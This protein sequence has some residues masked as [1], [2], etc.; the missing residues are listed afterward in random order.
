MKSRSVVLI[1]AYEPDVSLI[2][3]LREIQS[4]TEYDIVVV[5][6]GSSDNSYQVLSQA[7]SFA[8]V[9]NHPKNMGKGQAIKTGLQYIREHYP[10][11]T[12]IATMDADGQHK[13][14]DVI[15]LINAASDTNNQLII[16][17]RKFSG[18][19]PVRSKV[20][21][22][23]TRLVFMAL[24]RVNVGDTQ[25]GLRAFSARM[26]PFMLG[27]EGQRYEYEMNVL[28]G[29]AHRNIKI[30]EIPIETV[31]INNNQSSH[32]NTF[33]DSYMIYK[34]ILMFSASS[35]I[36]FLVDFCLYSILIWLTRDMNTEIRVPASN[37]AARVVSAS[38][39]FSINK[40]F[41]FKSRGSTFKAAA[42]YFVL[43]SGILCLNTFL[44]TVLVKYILKNK[45]I[46]KLLVEITLFFVNWSVQK[47]LKFKKYIK[48]GV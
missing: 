10:E 4:K 2:N 39:N 24:T 5:N 44:L 30:T 19:I 21:N 12:V 6:D 1:P 34:E 48:V 18:K 16:G 46:S 8:A 37:I 26:I 47:F 17:S 33:K 15:K 23:I 35:L 25:T 42:E 45:L 3:L 22:I 43:A 36:C 28:L 40:R 13:V 32:F 11:D 9:L 14:D 38:I 31:Y 41:V 20:G 27:V 7:A 29:C